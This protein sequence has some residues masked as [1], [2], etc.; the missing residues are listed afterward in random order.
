MQIITG[1][2]AE[3]ES[4]EKRKTVKLET[5]KSNMWVDFRSN[6]LLKILNGFK[7]G[8]MVQIAASSKAS[9]SKGLTSITAKSIKKL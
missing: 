6:L 5:G 9:K 3:I 4:S 7:I 8:D 1:T 2:I